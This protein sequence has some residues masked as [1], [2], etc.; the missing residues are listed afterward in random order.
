MKENKQI[1]KEPYEKPDVTIIELAADQVLA[2]GCK[3]DYGRRG[4][5]PIFFGCIM[6]NRCFNEG[7]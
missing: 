5:S 4:P 1:K 7:S 2:V 6:V 3:A